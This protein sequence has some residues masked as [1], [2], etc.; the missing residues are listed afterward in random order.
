MTENFK[1]KKPPQEEAN[2]QPQVKSL[3]KRCFKKLIRYKSLLFKE[4]NYKNRC[5][6]R[7]SKT[8]MREELVKRKMIKIWHSNDEKNEPANNNFSQK[9]LL[10]RKMTKNLTRFEFISFKYRHF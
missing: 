4:M 3:P 9:K 1:K 2:P 7:L 10:D 8:K 5:N 6:L